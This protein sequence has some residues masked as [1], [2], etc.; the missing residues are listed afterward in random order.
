[1]SGTKYP[2]GGSQTKTSNPFQKDKE[3]KMFNVGDI[4]KFNG[5]FYCIISVKNNVNKKLV[6]KHYELKLIAMSPRH[7]KKNDQNQFIFT[8]RINTTNGEKYVC[9][10]VE[11]K[12]HQVYKQ[13]IINR[14]E[15]ID[16]VDYVSTFVYED[17]D[18][19]LQKKIRILW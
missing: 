1:L 9:I 2:G 8:P 19:K 16:K 7:I 14:F 4:I 15:L 12:E 5:I 11:T 3:D 10:F 17:V 18:N 6:H 13:S